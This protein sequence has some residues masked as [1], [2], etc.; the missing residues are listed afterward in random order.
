MT[1]PVNATGPR[2]GRYQALTELG[3]TLG[4]RWVGV[5]VSGAERGRNVLLHQL[6]T[7]SL[8]LPEL[9]LL[10]R[11]AV[12]AM[13]IRHPSVARVLDVVEDGGGLTVV[14]EYAEGESLARLQRAAIEKGAPFPASVALSIL[15]DVVEALRAS[16]DQWGQMVRPADAALTGAVFGGLLPDGVWITSTGRTLL[17]EVGILGTLIR[18]PSVL[19]HAAV[20]PYRAPEQITRGLSNTGRCDVFSAGTLAWELM[21]N[22]PLFGE[23]ERFEREAVEATEA[24]EHSLL[25]GP[26]TPLDRL[27]GAG[28]V[29]PVVVD[30]LRNML[31]RDPLKR[32]PSLD[33]LAASIAEISRSLFA[34]DDQLAAYL[35][36]SSGQDLAARRE[37][38]ELSTLAAAL[39]GEAAEPEALPEPVEAAPSTDIESVQDLFADATRTAPMPEATHTAPTQDEPATSARGSQR[40]AVLSQAQRAARRSRTPPAAPREDA[41]LHDAPPA[42]A[43]AVPAPEAGVASAQDERVHA[44]DMHA[45]QP[46]PVVQAAPVTR[47][48][49]ATPVVPPPDTE[50]FE[51]PTVVSPE[52]DEHPAAAFRSEPAASAGRSEA[53]PVLLPSTRPSASRKAVW[54]GVALGAAALTV[55]IGTL[56]KSGP[57]P[58]EEPLAAQPPPPSPASAA[59]SH[60]PAPAPTPTAPSPS[61]APAA[62]KRGPNWKWVPW[63]S[64]SVP[65]ASSAPPVEEPPDAQV[66]PAPDAGSS[67]PYRPK[68]I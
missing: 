49:A 35:E 39:E 31:L 17:M 5:V 21:A 9:Q 7:G 68:G 56:W 67:G 11:A 26:I 37:L 61:A 2:L 34:S 19:R 58:V 33:K 57:A 54:V 16:G 10:N 38:L 3:C 64:A 40:A 50:L 13:V 48:A 25:H 41:P 53:A 32:Y 22:R 20:L 8:A 42:A 66:A 52:P 55:L 1:E 59:E 44:V 6:P 23:P 45:P 12:T 27:P 24:Q 36:R 51:R 65:A 18:Q 4:R 28:T 63:P 14:S 47:S 46:P 43:A 15:R 30:M 62:S 29:S 60:P